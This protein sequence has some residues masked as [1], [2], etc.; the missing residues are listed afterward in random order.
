MTTE[1]SPTGRD[2]KCYYYAPDLKRKR[3]EEAQGFIANNHFNAK[4]SSISFKGVFH[5]MSVKL[6]DYYIKL[7]TTVALHS[8]RRSEELEKGWRKDEIH[9]PAEFKDLDPVHVIPLERVEIA[10]LK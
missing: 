6:R 7:S 3:F 1:S 10:F 5:L 4:V 8:I 9:L 2:D